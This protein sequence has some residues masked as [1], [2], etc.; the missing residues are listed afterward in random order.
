M[1]NKE[2]IEVLFTP[3]YF[4]GEGDVYSRYTPWHNY[5]GVVRPIKEL[6]DSH[7]L[8]IS[9]YLRT[10]R[11]K[12]E[13]YLNKLKLREKEESNEFVQERWQSRLDSVNAQI[14][15]IDDEITL[16]EVDPS[17]LDEGEI[18]FKNKKGEDMI[19]Y[20]GDKSPQHIRN[21]WKYLKSLGEENE[22]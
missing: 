20:E 22:L 2:T 9:V 13:D 7:I 11:A 14:N 12:N 8:N 18:P 15:V 1:D 4:N 21:T 5:E 17:L 16:R 3:I 6:E 19:W 10:K